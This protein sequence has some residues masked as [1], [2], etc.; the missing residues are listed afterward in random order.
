[1]TYIQDK[2]QLKM[3]VKH[4][5]FYSCGLRWTTLFGREFNNGMNDGKKETL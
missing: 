5:Y 4:A 2:K 3:L 1:M